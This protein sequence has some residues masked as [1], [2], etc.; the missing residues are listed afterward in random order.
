MTVVLKYF[1]LLY[2]KKMV[3]EMFGGAMLCKNGNGRMSDG[4]MHGGLCSKV[5]NHHIWILLCPKHLLMWCSMLY[6]V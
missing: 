2:R 5:S 1:F 3:Q 6:I 4:K